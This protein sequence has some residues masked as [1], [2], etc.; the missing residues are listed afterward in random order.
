VDADPWS[1]RYAIVEDALEGAKKVFPAFCLGT[2]A[3]L[4][5][6]H[7]AL[8]PCVYSVW[9][10]LRRERAKKVA[11]RPLRVAEAQNRNP[12][13]SETWI[14]LQSLRFSCGTPVVC[15]QMWNASRLLCES[16]SQARSR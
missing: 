2:R 13:G 16:C 5:K 11:R 1:G 15:K 8:E 10:S 9:T 12:V 14:F 4:P 6:I 3:L 7:F